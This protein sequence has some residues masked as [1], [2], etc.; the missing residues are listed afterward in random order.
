LIFH[1]KSWFTYAPLIGEITQRYLVNG[2]KLSLK[3][4]YSAATPVQGKPKGILRSIR[5]HMVPG[6]PMLIVF[7]FSVLCDE[8]SELDWTVALQQL[9]EILNDVSEKAGKRLSR[10][11]KSQLQQWIM[12]LPA[13]IRVYLTDWS[14][15]S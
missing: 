1:H 5:T 4:L 13:Y 12:A 2:R 3:E 8:V 10:L 6:I 7:V 14:C 11:I 9:L 15:E